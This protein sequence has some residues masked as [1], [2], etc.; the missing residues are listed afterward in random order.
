MTPT[1][2]QIAIAEACGWRLIEDKYKDG[3]S[4][5]KSWVSPDG[6]GRNLPDYVNDLNAIHEAEKTLNEDQQYDFAWNLDNITPDFV[7]QGDGINW[8]VVFAL[9]HATASQRA[10]A[11][12]H[13]VGKWKDK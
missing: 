7:S 6:I 4:A 12:L 11:F 5:G 8:E 10:E 1:E 9:A 2:Q 13:T 3:T